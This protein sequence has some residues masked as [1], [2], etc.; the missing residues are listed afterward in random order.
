MKSLTRRVWRRLQREAK[1]FRHS[2]TGPYFT[3]IQ[4]ESDTSFLRLFD[5]DD[6][7]T[8]VVSGD[9]E[10]AK[11][12]LLI[13]FAHRLSP[14][15]PQP[16]EPLLDIKLTLSQLA[17]SELMA[18]AAAALDYRFML[19]ERESPKVSRTGQ[20]DWRFNPTPR[21]EWLWRLNRH[22]WWP[23]LGAAYQACGDERYARAFVAQMLDWVNR[24]PPPLKR[25]ETSPT[26]RLME[27]GMRLRTSWIPAFALFYDSPSFHNE[28]KLK[29]LRAIYDHAQFLTCFQTNRNHLLR[30]SNGLVCASLYFPEFYAAKEWQETALTRIDRELTKQVNQDGSHIEV[31]TGYQ[32]LVLDE[33]EDIYHLLQAHHLSLPYENLACRLETMYQVLTYLIRPDG[34]F[35]EINDGFLHWQTERLTQAGRLL[36]RPDFCYVG[37]QG[38]EGCPP[39]TTSVAVQDAGFCIMRSDWTSS[40]RYLFF[41]AGPFGGPHGHE[42][43]LNIEVSAFGQSFIVD[44]GSYT[45]HRQD[46]FRTYFVSSAAHNTILVDG[47]SQV[48]RWNESNLHPQTQPGLYCCWIQQEAFDYAEATY[49]EGYGHYA[50]RKPDAYQIVDDVQH[51]RRILFVKPDYWLIVDHLDSLG[52]HNYQLLFHIHSDLTAKLGQ[53]HEVTVGANLNTPQL[54]LI[55]ITYESLNVN[56]LKGCEEPIQGWYSPERL[57]KVE[58]TAISYTWTSETSTTITTL[59]YPYIPE[60][61]HS[62][63]IAAIEQDVPTN[64]GIAFKVMTPRGED[65]LMFATG[66]GLKQ[67]GSYQTVSRIAG[68]RLDPNGRVVTRFEGGASD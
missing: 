18:Q 32:C 14:G 60:P 45:Y 65:H 24:N 42:D 13:H 30:E 58:N 56:L 8:L 4:A 68:V 67:F 63:H 61:A 20:I 39:L 37:S 23:L 19:N 64:N 43:K 25:D 2:Q 34:T 33:F 59:L 57:K 1:S 66:S 46:P 48:R 52:P 21:D 10:A 17:H 22:Q 50:L 31:S 53:A 29:M 55:P 62:D 5:L 6:V 49:Q 41:D 51:T 44:S 27:V 28:A 7:S 3:S 40:A 9:I 12:V 15:W 26:W 38:A 16:P 47:L 54:R 36:N 35:P 11:Q